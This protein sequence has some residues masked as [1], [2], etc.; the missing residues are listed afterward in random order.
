MDA[1]S[2]FLRIPMAAAT[3]T[4]LS[5]A[6]TRELHAA[7]VRIAEEA[8]QPLGQVAGA[9]IRDSLQRDYDIHGTID[10]LNLNGRRH[11]NQVPKSGSGKRTHKG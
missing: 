1:A 2:P 6:V 11:R 10:R 4:R 5:V 9:L 7:I 3:K 8:Q